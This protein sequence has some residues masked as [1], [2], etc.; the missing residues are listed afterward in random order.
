MELLLEARQYVRHFPHNY[1]VWSTHHTA[2]S[3]QVPHNYS[4]NERSSKFPCWR[5]INL[6]IKQSET[7][8]SYFAWGNGSV[9]TWPLLQWQL[10]LTV[11]SRLSVELPVLSYVQPEGGPA[12]VRIA[13][14][15]ECS[16]AVRSRLCDNAHSQTEQADR[17]NF[18][19]IVGRCLFTMDINFIG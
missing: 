2:S 3:N 10:L 6:V 5:V 1:V 19:L 12:T 13:E 4:Q 9:I 8:S 18:W 16:S 15:L 7:K 11:Q 14:R 17:Q